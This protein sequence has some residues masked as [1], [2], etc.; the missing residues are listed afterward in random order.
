MSVKYKFSNRLNVHGKIFQQH[1][2]YQK[3]NFFSG[4]TIAMVIPSYPKEV[5]YQKR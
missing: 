5:G 4:A 2:L 3:Y 1:P